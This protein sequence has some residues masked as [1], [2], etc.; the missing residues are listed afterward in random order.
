M[1]RV[2]FWPQEMRTYYAADNDFYVIDK[3]LGLVLSA[4][5]ITRVPDRAQV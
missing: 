3:D 2:E 1:S 4:K 5:I